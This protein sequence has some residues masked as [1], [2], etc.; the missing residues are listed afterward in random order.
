MY[1][2]PWPVDFALGSAAIAPV[3]PMEHGRN[4]PHRLIL[5]SGW[6]P[7]AGTA[8]SRD[9]EQIKAWWQFDCGAVIGIVTWISLTSGQ[10]PGSYLSDQ[11]SVSHSVS[12]LPT[13]E[14][15]LENGLRRG[16][17]N[18]DAHRLACRLWNYH[19]PDADLVTSIMHDIWRVTDQV[20]DDQFPRAEVANCIRSAERYAGPEAEIHQQWIESLRRGL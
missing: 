2:G 6:S 13:T 8:G 14:W 15:F 17:R 11:T 19:C 7:K 12:D 1:T 16:Q 4:I 3:I 10:G 18:K 9:P 20:A 5:G